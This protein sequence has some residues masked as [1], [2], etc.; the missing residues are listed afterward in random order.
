MFGKKGNILPPLPQG[1]DDDGKYI[2]P[3][4]KIPPELARLYIP[5]KIPV[6]SREN[7]HVAAHRFGGADLLEYAVLYYP[8]ELRLY[9]QGNLADFIQEDRT[10]VGKFEASTTVLGGVGKRSFHVTEQ[11]ALYEAF[12]K[13]GAVDPDEGPLPAG[14]V[15]MYLF[16]YELLADTALSAYEYR[17]VGSRRLARDGQAVQYG[18]A[19]TDELDVAAVADLSAK[20]RVLG[21]YLLKAAGVYNGQSRLIREDF[22]PL[23]ILLLEVPPSRLFISSITP[24]HS[25]FIRMGTARMERVV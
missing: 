14:G 21:L 3:V 25:S 15:Q 5:G 22:E 8:Q 9:A 12:R 23:E 13:C 18:I 20:K 24:T 19:F 10:A 7:T 17:T 11:F 4:V 1:R 6:G 2:E 16:G